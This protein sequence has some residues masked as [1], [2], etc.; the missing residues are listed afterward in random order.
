MVDKPVPG[1]ESSSTAIAK[2]LQSGLMAVRNI[3]I[4]DIP[5]RRQTRNAMIDQWY[6]HYKREIDIETRLTMAQF[7][8]FEMLYSR[9]TARAL[10]QDENT[11]ALSDLVYRR[12]A[13][14]MNL[15]NSKKPFHIVDQHGNIIVT[16]PPLVGD[17]NI[18][19]D[20]SPVDIFQNMYDKTE[21]N[22]P[23]RAKADVHLLR[24][25][26]DAQN[27]TR[28]IGDLREF[29]KTVQEFHMRVFGKP[30]YTKKTPLLDE[31]IVAPE[32]QASDKTENAA[33]AVVFV[34]DEDE[35]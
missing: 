35:D 20:A 24:S 21:P 19:K 13:E 3:K 33:D 10:E 16:F 31:S 25:I 2:H 8:P 30:F 1:P 34:V 17:L 4:G 7:A 32:T 6:S 11:A 23:Q 12:S 18:L 29:D 5:T 15:V 14:L 28:I 9:E 22:S 26:A 27:Q